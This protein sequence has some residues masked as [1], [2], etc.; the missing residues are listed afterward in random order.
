MNRID[1]DMIPKGNTKIPVPGRMH[2]TSED[3]VVVGTNEVYDDDYQKRQ[4][5]IN[6]EVQRELT[7]HDLRIINEGRLREESD[8]LLNSEI[9]QKQVEIGAIETEL[10]PTPGSA[11]FLTSGSL[12]AN[13]GYYMNHPEWVYAIVDGA[14]RLLWGLRW[15]GSMY[16]AKGIPKVLED[17]ITHRFEDNLLAIEFE[18][19]GDIAAY[20]GE[21]GNIEDVYMGDNGD[22]IIEQ[23][24]KEG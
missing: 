15:D 3:H 7:L 17:Y 9:N 11:K 14:N 12:A 18:N 1:E 19:N 22:L 21:E 8:T 10:D 6:K 24:I 5:K 16:W 2:D 23:I 20:Y 13:Y 4:S